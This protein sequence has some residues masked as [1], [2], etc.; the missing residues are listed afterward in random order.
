MLNIALAGLGTVGAGVVRLLQQNG[1]VIAARAGQPVA[2]KAVSARDKNKKR[3][4]NL[5]GIEWVDDIGKLAQMT[6]I[7]AV[8]EQIGGAE[9]PVRELAEAALRNRKHYITANKALLAAHGVEL[10]KLAEQN[11][12]QLLFEAAVA[13]GI[14]VIK[15]LREGLAGNRISVVYGI[16]NGTCNVSS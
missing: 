6:G 10:A 2:V 3:D 9:G 8:V 1:G 5:S 16:I 11:G 4:C 7:D 12:V 14:P 15:A 13:G